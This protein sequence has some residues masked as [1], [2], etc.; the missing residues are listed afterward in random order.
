MTMADPGWATARPDDSDEWARGQDRP[1]QEIDFAVHIHYLREHLTRDARV[2]EAGAGGGRFTREIAPLVERVVVVDLS[3]DKLQ[4]NRRNAEAMGYA[5]SIEAWR[6]GDIRDLSAE[7]D[8]NEFDAVVCFGGPLSYALD[9]REAAMGE[10]V[11]VTRPGG[12][13]LVSARS[14]WGMLQ[15]NLP[16][17][18]Q[19]VDP[20]LNREIIATGTLG[21][22]KVGPV[23]RFWHAYRAIEFRDLVAGA[24]CE[25]LQLSASNC[26]TSTWDPVLSRWRDDERTWNHLIELEIEASREPGCLDLGTHI[27]AVARKL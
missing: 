21:P 12:L 8:D 13:L 9:R 14:L 1:L 5:G 6:T 19:S 25:V 4:S 23:D 2:L 24:G 11:R 16:R 15:E 10:L 26:L 7:F 22:R 27:L 17:I 18:L 20:R 3:E